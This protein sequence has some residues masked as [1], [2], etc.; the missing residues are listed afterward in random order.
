MASNS[1]VYD[2]LKDYI[3]LQSEAIESSIQSIETKTGFI[4]ASVGVFIPIIVA[5]VVD[6]LSSVNWFFIT[7]VAFAII[8]LFFNIFCMWGRRFKIS[9]NIRAF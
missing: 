2:L 5:D 8:T 1:A 3:P 6:G 9:P 4:M 7:G